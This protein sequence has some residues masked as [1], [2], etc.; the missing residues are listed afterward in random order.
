MRVCGKFDNEIRERKLSE[1][2]ITLKRLCIRVLRLKNK[3]VI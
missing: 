3:V 2:Q 1:R